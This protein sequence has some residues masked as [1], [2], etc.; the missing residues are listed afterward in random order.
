V[1]RRRCVS[2]AGLAILLDDRSAVDWEA[3]EEVDLDRED[4]D[5]EP[6]VD[7]GYATLPSAAEEAASY[8][9]WKQQF[10]EHLYRTRSLAMWRS[11]ELGLN[12]EPGETEGAFR[13]RL[14]D[15]ARQD[16]D[17]QA[18]R[19]RQK[20]SRRTA[21]LEDRVR[22]A[23]QRVERESEQVSGQRVQNAISFGATVL[24]AFLGR[25]AVS[26]SS[27]GRA[28]TAIRGIGRTSKEKHDVERARQDVES[29]RLELEALNR[30]L[31][32][33]MDRLEDRFDALAGEL[34]K[35][36]I[37]P[38]RGDVHVATVTLVWAP[39]DAGSLAALWK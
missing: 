6:D 8:R 28:T 15:R 3:A 33:E 10:S 39:H 22:R 35:T 21:R 34:E 25:K 18:D 17:K 9:T 19:L 2:D 37:R 36:A 12:S 38:R 5:R 16:R 32:G 1:V 27:V 20:Y 29:L 11:A 26:R 14:T 4:L 7:A 23:M 13:A 30:E 24:S 31:E